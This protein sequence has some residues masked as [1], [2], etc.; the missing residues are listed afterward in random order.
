MSHGVSN[1]V[2]A[3]LK[4]FAGFPAR[5]I[6]ALEMPAPAALPI[7]EKIPVLDVLHPIGPDSAFHMP[8][9]M[10]FAHPCGGGCL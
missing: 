1:A 8:V 7:G 4:S 3:A 2:R 10:Q 5:E 6:V 9:R